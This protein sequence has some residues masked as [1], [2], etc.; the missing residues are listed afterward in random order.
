MTAI[1][2][3]VV[4][5]QELVR[6]G[7]AMILEKAGLDVVGQAADGAEGIAL[8]ASLKPDAPAAT[9]AYTCS[10]RSKVVSTST[11]GAS[12]VAVI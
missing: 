10:S 1:R 12:L 11:F 5:D 7:F 2:V 4:D 9:A 3:V 8:A 6:T